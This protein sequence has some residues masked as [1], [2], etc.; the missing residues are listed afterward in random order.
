MLRIN[1]KDTILLVDYYNTS[2]WSNV[3]YFRILFIVDML[4]YGYF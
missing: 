3:E 4:T 1:Q 2:R